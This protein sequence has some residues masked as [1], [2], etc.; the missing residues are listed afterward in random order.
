MGVG[1]V[2]L[3]S[4]AHK[5]Y[6]EIKCL[7]QRSN[8]HGITTF[9]FPPPPLD[10]RMELIILICFRY[11]LLTSLFSIL[12]PLSLSKFTFFLKCIKKFI[13]YIDIWWIPPKN[14][15]TNEENVSQCYTVAFSTC[16]EKSSEMFTVRTIRLQTDIH[17]HAHI[18]AYTYTPTDINSIQLNIHAQ[19]ST[20][21]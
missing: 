14:I 8:R 16:S 13:I 3:L 5:K 2:K 20:G 7:T 1:P 12:P 9:I 21:L 18:H 19:K 15:Q 11:F 4:F 17:S 6:K 10:S